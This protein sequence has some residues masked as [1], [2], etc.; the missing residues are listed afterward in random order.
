MGSGRWERLK[1]SQQGRDFPKVLNFDY[2]LTR[3][4]VRQQIVSSGLS[5]L[6]SMISF[7][8]KIQRENQGAL[9]I[10]R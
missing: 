7:V 8:V 5:L 6:K 3:C 2:G 4:D 1:K 9:G 10:F